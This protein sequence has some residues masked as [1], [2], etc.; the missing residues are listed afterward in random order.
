MSHPLPDMDKVSAVMAAVAKAEIMP[1]YERLSADQI[2]NK[3]SGEP[4][5]EADIRAEQRLAEEL[6][7]LYP[8]AA[9]VGEEGVAADP[10]SAAPLDGDGPLWIVDPLDGTRNFAEGK[11]CFAVIIAFCRGGKTLAGWIHNPLDGQTAMAQIGEGAW[12]GGQ[13]LRV[14]PAAPV[15]KMGASLSR[16]RREKLAERVAPAAYPSRALRYGCLGMEYVDLTRGALHFAEYGGLKPWDHAAGLL[17]HAEAGG[18]A[19]MAAD[20]AAYR[21]LLEQRIRLL[22]APDR[23][24][25]RELRAMM[26]FDH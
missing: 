13:R 17:M 19:A 14:A 25:W 16:R 2:D 23:Q 7:S 22:V 1:L 20:E 10:K 11:P 21:P 8:G 15:G 18:F 24:S 26:D 3:V 6:S 4:V 9:V 5:T 12:M